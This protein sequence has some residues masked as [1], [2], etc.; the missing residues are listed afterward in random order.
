MIEKARFAR[1]FFICISIALSRMDIC[2]ID[3]LP[4]RSP[5]SH[6]TMLRIA[7]AIRPLPAKERGEVRALAS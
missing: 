2:L 5:G 1:A 7:E 4:C 6:R 3:I